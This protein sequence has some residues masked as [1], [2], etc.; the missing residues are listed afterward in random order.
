M[1][2]NAPAFT[3][4]LD[5]FLVAYYRRRPVNATFIGVHEYDDR[6]PDFSAHGVGDTV[7]E[8]QTLLRR[9]RE[10]PQEPLT[11]SEELDLRLAAGF[12]EIGLW[13]FGS[14][15][16]Q[17][18]NP[19][20]YTGE[21]NF[22]V[23]GLFLRPFAPIEQRVEAAIARLAA[24]PAL[25]AQGSANVRAAPEAWTGRAIRECTG[26][27]AFLRGGIDLLIQDFGGEHGGAGP[28]LRRAADEAAAAFG[29]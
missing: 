26:A 1:A 19:S 12:L 23:I 29:D 4:W 7:A 11:E 18:G 16:F 8:M 14:D 22:G 20:L 27:L 6:L 24:V 10:L 17:R 13:E 21:A 15:H 9:L 5:D 2:T 25:L 28:A 3:A